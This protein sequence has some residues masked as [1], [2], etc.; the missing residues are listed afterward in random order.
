MNN[1]LK[2]ILII[3]V[4]AYVISPDLMVGPVDDIIAGLI[5][6]CCMSKPSNR[7]YDVIE[8]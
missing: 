6:V 3:L 2:A 7:D 5:G 8:D 1:L 4:V